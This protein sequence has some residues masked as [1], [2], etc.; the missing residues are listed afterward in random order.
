MTDAA[1]QYDVFLSH[2]SA[3]KP[4]VEALAQRLVAAGFRPFLDRWHLIPGQ[5]W[6]EA[7]EQALDQSR[8]CVVFLGPNGVGP[9]ENEEMRTALDER[10]HS[11][12]FS[13]HPRAAACYAHA[14]TRP[15]APLSQPLDVGG[16]SPG[17]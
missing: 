9:W 14:R 6:Q 2:N 4:A 16:L 17:A 12:D 10:T 5:P 3:D 8:T 1:T 7:L 13:R 15:S 11:P